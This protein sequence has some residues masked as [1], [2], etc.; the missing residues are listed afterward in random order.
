[1]NAEEQNRAKTAAVEKTPY[2]ELVPGGQRRE[3]LGSV[4]I[5]LAPAQNALIS[6][7]VNTVVD[8]CFNQNMQGRYRVI[9]KNDPTDTSLS[10]VKIKATQEAR[11]AYAGSA[12]PQLLLYLQ[13]SDRQATEPIERA[14]VFNF[15]PEYLQ[16]EAI[17][18]DQPPPK[19][20]F[21]LQPVS[22]TNATAP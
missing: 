2:I 17:M 20:K 14:V 13:D 15:P 6:D 18:A 19:V 5:T 22:D 8:F 10:A 11:N 21:I 16:K 4:K 12:Y 1:L 7:Q 9:L 3:I